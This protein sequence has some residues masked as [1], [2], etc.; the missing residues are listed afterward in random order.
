MRGA[1]VQRPRTQFVKI[2]WMDLQS[3]LRERDAPWNAA[4]PETEALIVAMRKSDNYAYQPPHY[5]K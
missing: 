3:L 2:R 5:E 4:T 1:A